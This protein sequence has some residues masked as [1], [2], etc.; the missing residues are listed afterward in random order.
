MAR[1]LRQLGF[2]AAFVLAGVYVFAMFLGP[3]GWPSMMHKRGELLE[4]EKHNDN[5]RQQIKDE[6]AAIVQLKESGPA[7]DRVIREKTR[8]QKRSET[9]IYLSGPE[10]EAAH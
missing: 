7:R 8:K 2:L 4:M 5:L 3:N 6:G 1:L 9:T 10:D